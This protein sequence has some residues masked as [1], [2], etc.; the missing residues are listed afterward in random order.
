M[1]RLEGLGKLKKKTSFGTRTGEQPECS[2]VPQPTTL[3]RAPKVEYCGSK[4]RRVF[5][6]AALRVV[7]KVILQFL[8]AN[9]AQ[10]QK[11]RNSVFQLS[12]IRT[13]SVLTVVLA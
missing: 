13:V 6:V 2:I 4:P 7:E 8:H 3:P 10:I 9:N 11:Q 12:K 1:V 5:C